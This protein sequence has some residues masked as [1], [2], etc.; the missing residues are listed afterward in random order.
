MNNKIVREEVRIGKYGNK[1]IYSR[2]DKVGEGFGERKV[3]MKVEVKEYIYGKEEID[4]NGFSYKESKVN[5]LKGIIVRVVR[6]IN[7]SYY[8]YWYKVRLDSGE[9]VWKSYVKII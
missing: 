6:R 9:E 4:K 2:R 3:G 8:D 1:L 5:M 7:S